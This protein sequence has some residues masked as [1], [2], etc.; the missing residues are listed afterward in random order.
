MGYWMYD[1]EMKQESIDKKKTDSRDLPE[2]GFLSSIHIRMAAKNGATSNEDNHLHDCLTKIEVVGAG[3]KTYKS[4]SGVQCQALNWFDQGYKPWN[5]I[6]ESGG[7]WN[8]ETF[9]VN[10]GKQFMDTEHMLDCAKV[11][12]GK[13]RLTWNLEEV[14][15][16]GA[17]A[18]LGTDQQ[19]DVIYI[20][21][22]EYKGP[23]PKNYIKS[24]ET[25][26]W[27]SAAT[28]TEPVK[29]PRNN[30]IRRVMVRAWESGIS[31][32]ATIKNLKIDA[33]NGK[34][35]PYDNTLGKLKDLNAQWYPI[36]YNFLQEVWAKD[37]DTKEVHTAYSPD[38]DIY[39]ANLNQKA[40]A[41]SEAY[42]KVL[43]GLSDLAGTLITTETSLKLS[44]NGW[45]YHNCF[46]FPF[47]KPEWKEELLLQAQTFG[48]LDLEVK[49]GNAGGAISIVTEELAPNV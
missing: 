35:V 49:Q 40:W 8:I 15:T 26:A 48:K 13:L 5:E 23:A 34:Y 46:M 4:T 36:A 1:A 39:E 33:D 18:Y 43:I 47:D 11:L 3:G 2:T 17:T 21:P 41:R 22:H 25:E 44:T 24:T 42:G 6:R 20:M 45:G 9:V 10:F 31:P 14:R 30:P 28:G 7:Q 16:I 38:T 29:L 27:T 37:G 12:N 32:A 19:M